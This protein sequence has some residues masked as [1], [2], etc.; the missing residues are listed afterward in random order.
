MS[1]STTF[2]AAFCEWRDRTIEKYPPLPM[3]L[4]WRDLDGDPVT[5]PLL[6]WTRAAR[7]RRA[8]DA[9]LAAGD[10]DGP[11]TPE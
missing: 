2:R 4:P 3:T 1:G 9:V 11:S 5:V 10:D 7:T 8:V 6:A